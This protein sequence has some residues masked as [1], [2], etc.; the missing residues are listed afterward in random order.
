M[1]VVKLGEYYIKD[2]E[3]AFGGYLGEIV[4]SREIQRN[5]TKEGAE[6]IAQKVN[7]VV[8]EIGD[9]TTNE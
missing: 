8:V 7:G 1:Y 2:F 4:L 5:F 6:R 9:V 3:V